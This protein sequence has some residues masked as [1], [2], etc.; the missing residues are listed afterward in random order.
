MIRN[1]DFRMECLPL[2]TTTCVTQDSKQV[3][4]VMN[5]LIDALSS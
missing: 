3:S 2:L 5:I 1:K 4:S